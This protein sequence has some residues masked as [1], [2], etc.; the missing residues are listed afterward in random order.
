ML[1]RTASLATPLEGVV[2]VCALHG[3]GPADL[4]AVVGCGAPLGFLLLVSAEPASVG[5]GRHFGTAGFLEDKA[6]SKGE[7]L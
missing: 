1:L 6:S 3:G 2:G 5:L 4:V 7:G